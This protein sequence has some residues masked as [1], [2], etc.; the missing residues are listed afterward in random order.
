MASARPYGKY[1]NISS[2]A[3]SSDGV[4]RRST[5]LNNWN[6]YKKIKTQILI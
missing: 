1:A 2:K 6:E 3:N 4:L 5:Y